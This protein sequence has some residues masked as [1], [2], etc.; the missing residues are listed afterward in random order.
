MMRR[1]RR[2]ADRAIAKHLKRGGF[3][4]PERFPCPT[5]RGDGRRWRILFWRVGRCRTCWGT[6]LDPV[7]ARERVRAAAF[8]VAAKE[9]AERR[10]VKGEAK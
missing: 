2:A 6:G 4:I 10:S 3:L 7:P 8:L 1:Q 5:C 9:W